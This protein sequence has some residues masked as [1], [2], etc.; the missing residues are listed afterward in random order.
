MS[1]SIF[2]IVP[3]EV[4][5]DSRLTFRQMRV[6]IALLSFRNK[7]TNLTFPKREQLAERTG[8][9]KAKISTAT[10]ELCSLGW[11]KKTGNGGYSKPNQYEITVPELVTVTETGTVTESVTT[12]VTELVTPTVTVLGTRNKQTIEQINEQTIT[13]DQG[14]D[15]FWTNYP[16]KEAKANAVKAWGKLTPN[17][18]EILDAL[19]WQIDVNGWTPENKKYT[20]LPAT[21]LNSQRWLD[22]RPKEVSPF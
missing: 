9:D 10:T 19:S 21:Y 6:L 1:N 18:Y 13:I 16:R 5:M 20:P 3:I 17:V 7:A 11:L 15:L 2:A 8:L 22:E 12:T 4:L 14:F